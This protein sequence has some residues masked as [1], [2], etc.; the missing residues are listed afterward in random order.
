MTRYNARIEY[1]TREP[2]DD[3]LIHAL[4]DHH[5][6]TGRSARGWV[7]ATIS[8]PAESLRQATVTALALAEAALAA[9]VLALEVLPTVEF[10]ARLGA[11][12]LPELLTVSQV[13]EK[14]GVSRQAVLQRLE[15]GSLPGQKLGNAWA[16]PAD[17][18][19]SPQER[20][21][22]LEAGAA[23]QLEAAPGM[24]RQPRG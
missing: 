23:E 18:A 16:V 19:L 15:S 17:A 24:R 5:P 22:R 9:E 21:E 20:R 12:P 14:L 1:A 2:V 13:A 8:L 4:V 6:A 7:E 10:D 11:T 3:H